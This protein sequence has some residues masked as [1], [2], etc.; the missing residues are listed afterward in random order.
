M[1]GPDL[2]ELLLAEHQEPAISKRPPRDRWPIQL[3]VTVM[4][5]V[6]VVVGASA[7]AGVALGN[8]L[9]APR[10]TTVPYP[11]QQVERFARFATT[12]PEVRAAVERRVGLPDLGNDSVDGYVTLI[13][14]DDLRRDAVEALGRTV[15]SWIGRNVPFKRAHLHVTLR[16][17]QNEIG[18]SAKA[19]TNDDRF[20]LLWAGADDPR[21]QATRV[22]WSIGG[23]GEVQDL[24]ND[25]LSVLLTRLADSSLP[26]VIDTWTPAL[27]Q[28]CG[29]CEL[30]I[31]MVPP[32]ASVL[33][34]IGDLKG[35]K[36][37]A[38]SPIRPPTPAML[39]WA[40]AADADP[41]VIGFSLSYNYATLAVRSRDEAQTVS[42]RLKQFLDPADNVS[43]LFTY[44]DAE[45]TQRSVR[46]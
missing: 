43:M 16:V 45:G 8:V 26:D 38:F 39:R 15:A 25:S 22:G 1:Q 2:G 32:G 6:G 42:N 44:V 30:A 9:D 36:Q 24:N 46:G 18:L 20:R 12:L 17:G 21:L 14:Q 7:W 40:A 35:R 23:D 10:P 29:N 33:D 5:L 41:D 34:N 3:A 4:V 27:I 19:S 13:V 11:M 31:R 37:L 28:V